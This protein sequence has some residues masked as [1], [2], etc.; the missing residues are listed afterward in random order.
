M[1]GSV[2]TVQ[3]SRLVLLLMGSPTQVGSRPF[4]AGLVVVSSTTPA[5]RC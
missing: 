3:A 2:M 4:A 5:I 1:G